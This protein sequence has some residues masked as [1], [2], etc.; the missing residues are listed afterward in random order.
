MHPRPCF[1]PFLSSNE[2]VGG[3]SRHVVAAKGLLD[4]MAAGGALDYAVGLLVLLQ[5][6]LGHLLAKYQLVVVAG[7]VAVPVHVALPAPLV[8]THIALQRW[9]LVLCKHIIHTLPAC[10]VLAPCTTRQFITQA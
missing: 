3:R 6:L 4:A 8:L 7:L 1:G 2:A 10:S 5:A 9:A